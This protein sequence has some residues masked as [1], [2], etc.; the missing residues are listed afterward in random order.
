MTNV[1]K[2]KI[3]KAGLG[4][5]AGVVMFAGVTVSAMT[6]SQAQALVASLGITGAS[7][8]ALVAALTTSDSTTTTSGSCPT[9]STALMLGSKGAD[10]TKLQVVLNS[11]ADTALAVAAGTTGSAGHEGTSFGPATKAAVMKFQMKHHVSPTSGRVGPLTMSVLNGMCSTTTTTT[12]GTTTTTTGTTT[13]PV[14]AMLATDTPAAGTVVA[15]QTTADLL[16]V[17]FNGSG[18]VTSMTFQRTGMSLNTDLSNVYLYNG[19]TRISDAASV[20]SLG[21]VTFSGLN[22]MVSGSTNVAV[23]ADVSTSAVGSSVGL[24]MTGFT[25]GGTTTTVSLA[26]NSMFESTGAGLLGYVGF[27][28]TMIATSTPSVTAGT[29]NFTAWESTTNVG[30]HNMMLKSAAFQYTGSAPLTSLANLG[31]YVDGTKVASSAG[32]NAYGYVVFDMTSAPFT[33][34]TGT[35][36]VDVRADVV[37]GAS[38]N[39]KFTLQNAG[40]FMVTDSNVGVNAS[41]CTAYCGATTA[42]F[43]TF[44]PIASG[45]ITISGGSLSFVTDPSFSS[46]TNVTGGA[47]N[48]VIAKYKVNAYGEDAKITQVTVT[49]S[50]TGTPTTGSNTSTLQNVQLYYNGAPI[51]SSQQWSG[52][53]MLTFNLN[54]SLIIPAGTTSSSFEIH[55]DMRNS[56]GVNYASGTVN[57]AVACT[58][59]GVYSYNTLTCSIPSSTALT[60]Q[61]GLLSMSKSSA[62][63]NQTISPNTSAVQLG[64]YTLANLS[65][66]EALHVTNIRVA[67]G[68]SVSG[69]FTALDNASCASGAGYGP[70]INDVTNVRTSVTSGNGATPQSSS[71]TLDYTVDF[72][73]PANG[74]QTVNVMADLNTATG[75]IVTTMVPTVYGA[76]SNALLSSSA[77]TATQGQTITVAAGSMSSGTIDSANTSV[78]QYVSA[79]TAAS[80]ATEATYRFTATNGA[81]T[82]NDMKFLV[83][84]TT[85]GASAQIGVVPTITI[86]TTDYNVSAQPTL[87]AV[88]MVATSTATTSAQS[89][90][91][92]ST[93]G[94]TAGNLL[95][96]GSEDFLVLSITDATHV[97]AISAFGTPSAHNTGVSVVTDT[98]YGIATAIGVNVSVPSGTGG[99]SVNVWGNYGAVNGT[100]GAISSGS[101]STIYLAYIKSTSGS[102]VTYPVTNVV[103]AN[104][105]TS[106]GAV[107]V[108]TVTSSTNTGLDIGGAASNLIGQITVNA[109]GQTLSVKTL[110]FNVGFSNFATTTGIATS[111]VLKVGSSSL[112]A[113]CGTLATLAS[114][115][116]ISCTFTTGTYYQFSGSVTFNLYANVTGTAATSASAAVST[117]LNEID[118]Q[119]VAGGQ[120]GTTVYTDTQSSN[121]MPAFPTGSY[122]IKQS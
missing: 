72:T 30:L 102:T 10:V 92:S 28:T 21:T 81:A 38:R 85:S 80:K 16:H 1:L 34:T 111:T 90:N 76:S 82:I 96:I 115:Q 44:S 24:T 94:L 54:S 118:W 33:L 83:K 113:T 87:S 119:D 117:S 4:L 19:A 13:G 47:T 26:G 50:V 20:N 45:S 14:T 101:L 103:G 7:A 93:A 18:T 23:K 49:P 17:A 51:A 52:S 59:N 69:T 8:T 35:H 63:L 86:G 75:T 32:V 11:D 89:L 108:L 109:N 116:T 9:F 5:L 112:T 84:E 110:K 42:P 122:T 91:I 105:I 58:A 74:T 56:D 88:T 68:C 31:L 36:I 79:A 64:S 97:S 71:D 27:T 106:V 55:A 39:F 3:A 61:T 121:L 65:S 15:G 77:S 2:S 29:T 78:S 60:I 114:G 40:D 98:K 46:V 57:A 22:F 25:A 66:S 6:A 53:G 100:T 12:T 99:Q 37:N 120:T 95:L 104:Q 67:L 41:A 48:A 107:P 70:G 43:A 73:I 62:Y